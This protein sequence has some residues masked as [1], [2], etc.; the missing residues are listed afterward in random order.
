[1]ICLHP[2]EDTEHMS[3]L[4]EARS[5][6]GRVAADILLHG[7]RIAREARVKAVGG[8]EDRA[9]MLA[10]PA[11]RGQCTASKK[12]EETTKSNRGTRSTI[13][14]CTSVMP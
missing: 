3:I 13:V 14:L 9:V 12:F 8:L 2:R 1:M 10:A 11:V 6:K 4:A 5:L 7:G